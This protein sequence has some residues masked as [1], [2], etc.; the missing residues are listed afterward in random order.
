M[1]ATRVEMVATV[2]RV[3]KVLVFRIIHNSQC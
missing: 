2:A 1:G 3:V